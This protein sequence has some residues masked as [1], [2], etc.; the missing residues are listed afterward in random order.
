MSTCEHPHQHRPLTRAHPN[1]GG[2]CLLPVSSSIADNLPV[3]TRLEFYPNREAGG[4]DE[5]KKDGVKDVQFE[6]GYR[7]GF[8]DNNKVTTTATQLLSYVFTQG[9]QMVPQVGPT[10]ASTRG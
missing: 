4:E 6:H 10:M 3:A 5:Q 8:V 2:I 7:L 1:P 9:P